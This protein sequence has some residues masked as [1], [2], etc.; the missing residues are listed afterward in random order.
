MTK[1]AAKFQKVLY[2]TVRGAA[3]TSNSCH[4]VTTKKNLVEKKKQKAEKKIMAG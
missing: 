2:K 4:L 3:P 1:K